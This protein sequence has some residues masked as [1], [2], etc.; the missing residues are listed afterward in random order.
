M[1]RILKHRRRLLEEAAICARRTI[2]VHALHAARQIALGW[3]HGWT[4]TWRHNPLTVIEA[5]AW[6]TRAARSQLREP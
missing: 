3:P 6:F 2:V 1:T 5:A 4:R